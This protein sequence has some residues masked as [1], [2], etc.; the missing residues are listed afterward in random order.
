MTQADDLRH[1]MIREKILAGTLPKEHCRMTW[2]GRGTGG[3]CL[4]CDRVI[5]ADEVEVECDLP[6]GGTIRL[7]R[8]CYDVWS[9]V[10]PTCDA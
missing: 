8:W 7:H 9:Q 3:I 6:H 5:T 1:G 4:A 10:W 2:Y